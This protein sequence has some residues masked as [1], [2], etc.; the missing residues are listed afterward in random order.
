MRNTK[1]FKGFRNTHKQ[2]RSL[3]NR[4]LFHFCN[5]FTNLMGWWRMHHYFNYIKSEK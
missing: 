5:K 4:G 1:K 3:R 2:T